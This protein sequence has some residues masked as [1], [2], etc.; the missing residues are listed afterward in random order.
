MITVDEIAAYY[1]SL[2]TMQYQDRPKARATIE[3]LIK[4]VVGNPA[5]LFLGTREAFNL[6]TAVG[7]QL[8]F[9]GSFLGVKRYL[10][11]SDT[12][13]DYFGMPQTGDTVNDFFGMVPYADIPGGGLPITAWYWLTYPDL[14]TFVGELD[15]NTFRRLLKY[16]ILLGQSDCSIRDIDWI[17]TTYEYKLSPGGAYKSAKQWFAPSIDIWGSINYAISVT[18]NEDMTATYT[19]GAYQS[20]PGVDNAMLIS[21]IKTLNAFPKP[22]GV[23]ITVVG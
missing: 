1:R 2:L 21:A 16:L 15:D 4:E 6:E 8:D 10:Y 22:A 14:Y 3:M 11:G 12:A 20:G 17:F 19:I 13:K 9:L 5:T 18:D 23:T 7:K